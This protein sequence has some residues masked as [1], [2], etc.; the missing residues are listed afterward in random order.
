MLEKAGYQVIPVSSAREALLVA[1]GSAVIDAVVTDVV[2]PGGMSGMEMGERLSR[3]RPA[4]PVLY[5]SGYTDDIRF[6]GEAS[7]GK[8]PF[9][10]KPFPPSQLL[11]RVQEIM[12]KGQGQEP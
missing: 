7:S 8:L 9:L 2:M 3:S 11:V 4:L 6:Q 1:E 12:R 5:M 10:G